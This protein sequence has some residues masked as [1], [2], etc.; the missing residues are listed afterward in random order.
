MSTSNAGAV[1][2]KGTKAPHTL[3]RAA[4][5]SAIVLFSEQTP[6]GLQNRAA[7]V[8]QIGPGADH[9][10]LTMFLPDGGVH[11]RKNVEYS[12]VPTIGCWTWPES[13]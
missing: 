3:E 1:T 13:S 12:A 9:I 2:A 4:Y 8:T 10:G 5:V 6:G 11:S 7:I